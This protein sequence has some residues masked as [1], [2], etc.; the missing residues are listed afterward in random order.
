MSNNQNNDD[1]EHK[2]T[3]RHLKLEDYKDVKEMW[4]RIYADFTS[5]LP[6]RQFRSQLTVFPEGQIASKIMAKWLPLRFQ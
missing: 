2:L 5:A 3:L 4:D 1:T 6:E